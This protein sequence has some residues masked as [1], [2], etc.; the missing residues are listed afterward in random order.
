MELQVLDVFFAH[1]IDNDCTDSLMLVYNLV[2]N[3]CKQ[4]RTTLHG[5]WHRFLLRRSP[6]QIWDNLCSI[7]ESQIVANAWSRY[8][9][10]RLS[11]VANRKNDLWSETASLF[12][13]VTV[14]DFWKCNAMLPDYY[15]HFYSHR[16]FKNG[17][18]CQLKEYKLSLNILEQLD[19]N[20]KLE[21]VAKRFA[22]ESDFVH[23][24]FKFARLL[25]QSGMQLFQLNSIEMQYLCQIA[26]ETNFKEIHFETGTQATG[27]R[28]K[29]SFE[30]ISDEEKLSI[31]L[32]QG[33]RLFGKDESFSCTTELLKKATRGIEMDLSRHKNNC[34]VQI[35]FYRVEKEDSVAE[36]NH[37]AIALFQP[38]TGKC[39]S[40]VKTS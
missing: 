32:A 20:E 16:V 36:T 9:G 24:C 37:I 35:G 11:P 18:F 15:W 28:R 23:L 7:H 21:H 17:R 3:V 12:A 34:Q 6:E 33:C 2:F 8:S 1:L 30:E 38:F 4:F 22:P 10:V 5:C 27:K 39:F 14:F 40:F 25:E 13:D 19:N 26:A 29:R 31:T